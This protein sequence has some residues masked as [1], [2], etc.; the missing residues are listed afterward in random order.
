MPG[1]TET[2]RRLAALTEIASGRKVTQ[3]SLAS[4]LGVSL[5]LANALLRGLEKDGLVAVNR[6]AGSQILRYAVTRAGQAELLLLALSGGEDYEL[7][8]TAPPGAKEELGR[9][10]GQTSVP[11]TRIGEIVAEAS[12]LRV[13]GPDGEVA[14]P[15]HRGYKHFPATT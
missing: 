10:A 7:L 11:I 4:R 8:F 15:A 3:R 9:I 12:G 1:V 2:H 14:L 5:G 13:F 6:S